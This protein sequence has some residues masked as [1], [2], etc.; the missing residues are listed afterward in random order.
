MTDFFLT[1]RTFISP[2]QLC[3]LLTL[4]FRWALENDDEDRRVVR[5]SPALDLHLVPELAAKTQYRP[6]VSTRSAH[7]QGPETGGASA[8]K[9]V[10]TEVE[11]QHAPRESCE[12]ASAAA[13]SREDRADGAREAQL[14][15][16]AEEDTGNGWQHGDHRCALD[17]CCRRRQP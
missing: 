1:Y 14:A 5:I 13:G 9:G 6:A 3:K 12:G 8:K 15:Q 10:L 17:T 2:V 11:Q 4:R 16:P 7:C